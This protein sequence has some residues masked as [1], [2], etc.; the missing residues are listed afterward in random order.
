MSIV[1]HMSDSGETMKIAIQGRF[2]FGSHQDFRESYDKNDSSV[3]EY[4][5]D[6]AKTTYLDSSALGMLLLLRDHAGSSAIIKIINC[7][8][9]VFKIFEI[10]N[11]D[12]LFEIS[13]AK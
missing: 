4:Y 9:E 5:V 11:F 12:Q 7:N 6:M 8:N 10:S 2:D 1:S 13:A 3:K